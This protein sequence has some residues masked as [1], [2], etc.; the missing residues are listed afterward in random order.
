MW[1]AG[2]F[3][4]AQALCVYAQPLVE[5]KRIVVV[6]DASSRIGSMLV[7]LGAR[8]VHVSDTGTEGPVGVAPSR[9]VSF[10]P[11]PSGDFDVRDG[12]FDLAIIPDLSAISDRAALLARVRRIIGREGALLVAARNPGASAAQTSPHAAAASIDY[13]ELYELISLQFESVRMIGQ[14][15]FIGVALVELGLEGEDT[16]VSVDA[17]LAGETEPPE[18]FIALASQNDVALSPYAIVQLPQVEDSPA[19]VAPSSIGARAAIAESGLRADALAA[20]LDER[21]LAARELETRAAEAMA[22][23]ERIAADA[24][25]SEEKLE[26]ERTRHREQIAG[27]EEEV[28]ARAARNAVLEGAFSAMEEASRDLER[29]VIAA[30]RALEDRAE[31]A[32]SMLVELDD[33]RAAAA[34]A[35]ELNGSAL[36]HEGEVAELEAHLRNRGSHVAD[37]EREIAR[38]EQIVLDLLSQL[39]HAPKNGVL[40][41]VASPTTEPKAD[42]DAAHNRLYDEN[43]LLRSKLDALALELARREGELAT[44]AW[45]VTELDEELSRFKQFGAENGS[46]SDVRE[47]TASLRADLDKAR[48][49]LDIL[50]RALAQEHEARVRREEQA[51]RPGLGG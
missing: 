19:D 36:S 49:E 2:D 20:Q 34:A 9:G 13:Y 39:Q 25:R 37:L 31:Q 17:Q 12:A 16:E 23:A 11:L 38:R 47:E 41:V 51:G 35:A 24:S 18:F 44:T 1:S 22:M 32:A 28:A 42:P 46:S 21:N 3:S 4:S 14:V 27:Y 5:G 15:P 45:R 26:T 6:G 48:D 43:V 50:R 10:M 33:A 8:L 40:E 30:E 7:E 29:R